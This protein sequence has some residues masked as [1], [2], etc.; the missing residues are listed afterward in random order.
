[1]NEKLKLCLVGATAVG[2]T[3]LVSRYVRSIFSE[4]YRTTIGVAIERRDE[5][6]GDRTVQLVIWDL[7]G[8]DEFQGVQP[9]YLRGA[10]GFILV[11]DGTRLDTIDT[12][13]VL[14]ERAKSATGGAPF[15]IAVNKA[16]LEGYWQ[17][18]PRDLARLER[19]GAPIIQTSAKTGARVEE[20]FA[21]IVAEIYR[22]GEHAWI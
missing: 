10:A 4:R 19:L 1:M 17:L 7:S 15:V 9:A 18:R 13:I 11:V 5:R 21:R 2:K 14:A 16:D 22:V 20:T 8:E 6:F 12:A 3:S